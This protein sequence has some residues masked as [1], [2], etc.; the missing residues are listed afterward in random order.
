M[1]D[2][3]SISLFAR[4]ISATNLKFTQLTC[5]VVWLLI[6]CLLHP[7]YK[8]NMES[9]KIGDF[10]NSKGLFFRGRSQNWQTEA[11]DSFDVRTETNSKACWN[12]G[13][14]G[15]SLKSPKKEGGSPW[16]GV[17]FHSP[18]CLEKHFV[19]TFKCV[20]MSFLSGWE[21]VKMFCSTSTYTV[22][23]ILG[24]YFCHHKILETLSVC[25]WNW[26]M[27]TYMSSQQ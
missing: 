3:T 21:N 1:V 9:P 13:S 25:K 17:L 22:F 20:E 16:W 2:K 19:A 18:P 15:Y 24:N 6:G 4:G 26:K 11:W 23:V 5:K 14:P 10:S 12:H 27:S 8:T 7:L